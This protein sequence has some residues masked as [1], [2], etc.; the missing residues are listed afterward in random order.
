MGLA[1]GDFTGSGRDDLVVLNRAAKSFTLLLGLGQGRLGGPRPDQTYFPTSEH[2]SQIV[3][4][5]LPGDRLP[6]VA[7]LMEDLGQIWIYRNHGDGTF[8]TPLKIDAGSAPSGFSVA[9][10]NGR[11]ALLVG[12]AFGDIL[13]LLYDGR[14]GFAP[15]VRTC[16]MRRW[17]WGR[18]PARLSNTP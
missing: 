11:L 5:T 14:G 9:Q 12:N 4:L 17:P 15:I 10:V 16:N 8:A 3:G 2:P 13:T 6:S 18:L 1:A 7:I